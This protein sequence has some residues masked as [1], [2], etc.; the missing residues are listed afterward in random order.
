MSTFEETKL[1]STR[2]LYQITAD[3]ARVEKGL[4]YP[5]PTQTHLAPLAATI[6]VMI[7]NKK[8]KAKFISLLTVY[9]V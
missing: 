1:T 5:C 6:F 7:Y 3:T 2:I 9:V 8:E 4:S